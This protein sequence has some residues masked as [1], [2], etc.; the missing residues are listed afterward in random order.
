PRQATRSV[1]VVAATAPVSA[2]F[3]F[4]PVSP[5]AGQDV[6]FTD[7]TTGNATSWSWNFGDGT[8]SAAQNP[9]KRYTKAGTYHVVLTAT[10]N[11]SSSSSATDIVVNASIPATPPVAA[12]FA[13]SPSPAAAGDAVSFIDQ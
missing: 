10:G 9:V 13:F 12:A 4:A 8:T 2:A 11:G 7:A 5:V 3:S 6:T 1:T